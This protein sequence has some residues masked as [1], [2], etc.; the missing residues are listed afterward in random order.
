LNNSQEDLTEKYTE[1]KPPKKSEFDGSSYVLNGPQRRSDSTKLFSEYELY[2][3]PDTKKAKRPDS[4]KNL[5]MN[6]GSMQRLIYG[7]NL[8]AVTRNFS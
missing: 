4:T 7:S 5:T 8:K 3:H 2:K 6:S 1:S